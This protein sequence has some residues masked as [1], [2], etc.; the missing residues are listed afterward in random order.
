MPAFEEGLYDY[1][2][3]RAPAVL[4]AIRESGRLDEETE[5]QLKEA[6]EAYQAQFAA[7]PH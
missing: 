3:T 4:D 6:L 5:A 1:L 2:D 7:L